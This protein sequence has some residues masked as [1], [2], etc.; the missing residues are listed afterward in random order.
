MDWRGR[1]K[2]RERLETRPPPVK[3]CFDVSIES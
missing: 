2:G 1:E 3:Q